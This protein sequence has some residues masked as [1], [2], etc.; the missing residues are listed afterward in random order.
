MARLASWL[1]V[2]V[3]LFV[4]RLA[5]AFGSSTSNFYFHEAGTEIVWEHD[6]GRCALDS[7]TCF[8]LFPIAMDHGVVRGKRL[9]QVSAPVGKQWVYGQSADDGRFVVYD[10]RT[11]ELVLETDSEMVALN[12]YTALAGRPPR[13]LDARAGEPRRPVLW[14]TP[15]SLFE[16]MTTDVPLC[17]ILWGLVMWP[18]YLVAMIGYVVLARVALRRYGWAPTVVAIVTAPALPF[19]FWAYVT[20]ALA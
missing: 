17:T 14:R 6:K 10:A 1:V 4:P 7:S 9:S 20:I 2:V 3:L 19:A 5:F 8:V 18:V 12:R 16:E 11:R 15:G 13:I